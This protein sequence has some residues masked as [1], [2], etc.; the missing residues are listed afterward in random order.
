MRKVIIKSVLKSLP[1]VSS[2]AFG[3]GLTLALMHREKLENK[4]FDKLTARQ[5]FKEDIPLQ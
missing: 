2:L 1:V 3:A 4:I 5:I